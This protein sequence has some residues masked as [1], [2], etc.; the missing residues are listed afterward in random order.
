MNR[1]VIHECPKLGRHDTTFGWL[2]GDVHFDE[3]PRRTFRPGGDG[4]RQAHRVDRVDE[5]RRGQ[6]LA[7]L[8]PLQVADE[9]E[10]QAPLRERRLG[11]E[12]LEPVLPHH[13]HARGD[14]RGGVLRR[15][16]TCR[17]A[18][19]PPTRAGGPS[20]RRPRPGARASRRAPRAG[21]RRR[22]R[23]P[24]RRPGRPHEPRLAPAG[25]AVAAVR[26]EALGLAE[27][28]GLDGLD[29]RRRAR[30]P[31]PAPRGR[32]RP[33]RPPGARPPPSPKRAAK[34]SRTSADTG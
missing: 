10:G 31:R 6:H 34:R 13:A 33:G 20:A 24:P 25:A 26:V 22:S 4:G 11:L 2:L 15:A 30:P 18:P 32:R 8:A 1:H 21:R 23:A 16:R 5:P 28:A 29:R 7:H 3:N 17:R 19:A 14:Q 27:G 12:V 9:V